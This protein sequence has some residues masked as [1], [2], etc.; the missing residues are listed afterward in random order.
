MA[1][2]LGPTVTL[3]LSSDFAVMIVLPEIREAGERSCWLVDFAS[4]LM[5]HYQ[6]PLLH[7]EVLRTHLRVVSFG[8]L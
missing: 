2:P 6:C 3:L 7:F 4:R 5:A 8:I 1:Q